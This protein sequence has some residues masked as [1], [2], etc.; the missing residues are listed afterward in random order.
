MWYS[1]GFDSNV[2]NE[3]EVAYGPQKGGSTAKAVDPVALGKRL[4][5]VNCASCHQPTGQGAAGQYPPLVGSDIVLSKNGYGEN[6]LVRVMLEG[7]AGHF[8]V[9]GGSYNGNMPAWASNLKDEQIAYILTYIRQEWG[10]Q[11]GPIT[12]EAV[13]SVRKET[14]D[15]SSPWSDEELKAIAPQAV[16]T[17]ATAAPQK[18]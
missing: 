7:L 3:E 8:N 2:Y 5:T 12:P 15:R 10:N 17:P 9:C 1:G 4:Y 11:A 14:A 16:G 18:K 6:H 13:A